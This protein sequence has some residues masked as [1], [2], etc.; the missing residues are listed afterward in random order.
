MNTIHLLFIVLFLHFFSDF[1]LQIGASLHEMK[2]RKW[3]KI[4]C[5][6]CYVNFA[7][8]RHDWLVALVIH[9]LVWSIVTFAPILYMTKNAYALLLIVF[10]NTA[11]H[12][13]I[14]HFKANKLC[15]NLLV[16]QC[17]HLLQIA[18]TLILWV[19]S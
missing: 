1:N 17:L 4:Q 16:D 8:Y 2:Q 11:V 13:V 9:S 7:P 14:D 12:S 10:V 15:I 3:W 19:K 5:D 18:S 6:K